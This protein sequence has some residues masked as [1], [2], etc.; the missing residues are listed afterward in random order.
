MLRILHVV[1][2]VREAGNGISNVVVDL[3]CLQSQSGYQVAVASEGGEYEALLKRYSVRHFELNNLLHPIKLLRSIVGYSS[4]IREFQPN[5]VHVHSPRGVMLASLLKGFGKYALVGTMHSSNYRRNAI[6]MGFCTDRVIAIASLVAQILKQLGVPQEK[7]RVVLNG[8]LGSPRTRPIKEYQPASLQ[9]PAVVCVAG[10]HKRK[11]I[12]ELI[13]AFE[14]IAWD[15]PQAH[16]YLVG[17]GSCQQLFEAQAQSTS[18]ADRIHFEGFQPQ[19]QGYLLAADIFV[20][21]SHTEPFGLALS[22]AREAG[23]AIIAS[24]VDGIPEVLDAG[25]AGLLIPPKNSRVLAATLSRLLG[26]SNILNQW[27]HQAKQN[28]EWLT[29]ERMCQETLIVYRDLI[30]EKSLSD[31]RYRTLS[32]N[33]D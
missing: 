25:R 5:I 30:K 26:D 4:I 29:A 3:A 13:N 21:A 15:Y 2:H 9:H 31:S 32:K 6:L 18:V 10:M 33:C 23:C 28:L 8:T 17:A 14:Q 1:S 12:G 16:L 27:K 19:P 11:G 22:E 7:L 20:L 24:N